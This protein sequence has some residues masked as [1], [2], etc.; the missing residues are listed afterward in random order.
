MVATTSVSREIDKGLESPAGELF[1]FF[2]SAFY[3]PEESIWGWL[4]SSQ[5]KHDLLGTLGRLAGSD[6]LV[7][8]V[9]L[10]MDEVAVLGQDLS[11]ETIEAAYIAMFACGYPRVLCPPY[12]SL[13]TA[14]DEDKRLEGMIA[15]KTFYE[16]CGV[17]ITD[18]FRDLPDHVCVE[19]EFLQYMAYEIARTQASGDSGLE[20]IVARHT[21]DFLDQYAV[22]LL[23]G[24][25]KAAAGIATRNIYCPLIEVAASVTKHYR[26]SLII[27][28]ND[29]ADSA[30]GDEA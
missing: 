2:S 5:G 8:T 9:Q 26:D 28:V 30:E 25:S 12:G 22:G 20:R 27:L 21:L 1:H 10:L 14:P 17:V 13:Y 15:V 6:G 3:Y 16:A 23:D 11:F 24:M 18:N 29:L 19:F 4:P 7:A